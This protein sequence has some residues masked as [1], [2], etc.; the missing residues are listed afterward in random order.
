MNPVSEAEAGRLIKL[1]QKWRRVA[2]NEAKAR[3]AS[4]DRDVA[5]RFD[6]TANTYLCCINNLEAAAGVPLAEQ[7]Q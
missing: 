6:S 4:G 3:H 7:T 1:W 5:R 2:T